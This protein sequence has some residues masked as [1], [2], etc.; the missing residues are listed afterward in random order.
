[1]PAQRLLVLVCSVGG[2]DALIRV[3]SRLPAGLPAC[4]LVLQHQA[5]DHV[6]ELAS[7]LDSR[8]RLPVRPAVQGDALVDGTVLVAPPGRH[9]LVTHDEHLALIHSGDFPP[10][11]PSADLL[12]TSAALALRGRAVAVVL[13]GGG[14]DGATGA[15]AVHDF[16]GI[17]I[18]ADEASSAAYDMPKATIGRDGAIDH[19]A[20]VDDIGPLLC[21]LVGVEP[22][23]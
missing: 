11:R 13:S 15:T 10:S 1:M 16:G 12:L 19:V 21:R 7:I 23:G 14:H 3:L 9:L 6:S 17:V 8:C 20:H 18:A 2:L 4:V 22:A 5:P